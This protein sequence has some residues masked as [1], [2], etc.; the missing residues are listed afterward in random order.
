MQGHRCLKMCFTAKVLPVGIL[1]PSHH[2]FFVGEIVSVLEVFET[3][4]ES[5]GQSGSTVVLAVEWCV[6]VIETL[7]LHVIGELAK[8]MI[9]IDLV[10]ELCL[11]E[12]EGRWFGL[13]RFLWFHNESNLQC[14]VRKSLVF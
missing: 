1:K 7:P 12:L 11:E 6:C 8:G 10:V 13:G 2:E 5:S 4:H 9:Q 3:D 14:I